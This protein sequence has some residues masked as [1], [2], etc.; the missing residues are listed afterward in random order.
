MDERIGKLKK[1]IILLLAAGV[2]LKSSRSMS[3]QFQIIRETSKEWKTINRDSLKRSLTS[4]Y[5]A[6][7][8]DLH[9]KGNNFEIVLSRNGKK[10]AAR[11]DLDSLKINTK[12]AWDGK[13]RIVLFDIPETRKKVRE[14][15]R[16]H[17]KKL[18]LMEYQKSV[19]ISPYSC[20]K[21]IK[22]IAEFY[23]ARRYIR[24]I[25]SIAIDDEN[26]FKKKFGIR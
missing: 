24:F 18:G 20:Q 16:F 19:F 26:K 25:V 14:A 21:E 22:F 7:L 17:F 13:W 1:K 15:I 9:P 10:E 8:I 12:A 23:K 4:L 11:F 2:A 5:T 3:K 6:K